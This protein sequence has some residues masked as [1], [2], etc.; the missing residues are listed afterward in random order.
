ME[1]VDVVTAIATAIAAIAAAV[2]ACFA[3]QQIKATNSQ[4]LFADRMSCWSR[5]NSLLS[6]FEENRT[7]IA[8]GEEPVFAVDLYATIL[9]NNA[10]LCDMASAYSAPLQRPHHEALRTRIEEIRHASMEAEILFTGEAAGSLS[11]FLKAY[12]DL[13]DVLYRYA[14]VIK[15]MSLMTEEQHWDF[16]KCCES[17]NELTHRRELAEAVDATTEAFNGFQRF[18]DE[19]IL[20]QIRVIAK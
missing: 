19:A 14:I 9:T 11:A 3:Y 7:Q 16:A 5:A 4:C 17:T 6:L 12:A 15:Q 1:C 2:T 10:W 13:L 20:S 8:V 18:G